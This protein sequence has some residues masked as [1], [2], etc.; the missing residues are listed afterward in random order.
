MLH[1]APG[2]KFYIKSEDRYVSAVDLKNSLDLRKQVHPNIQSVQEVNQ[3][4]EVVRITVDEHHNFYVSEHEIL[5]HNFIDIGVG[6]T[7]YFGVGGGSVFT[8]SFIV[9]TGALIGGAVV[10][11]VKKNCFPS[12]YQRKLQEIFE[13]RAREQ[14]QPID[15]NQGFKPSI[16]QEEKKKTW[17]DAARPKL[18]DKSQGNN[19]L[20]FPIDQNKQKTYV[21][22]SADDAL[23]MVQDENKNLG[24]NAH[25]FPIDQVKQKT[26]IIWASIPGKPTEKDGFF[27]PK[28][29]DGEKVPSSNGK[30]GWQDKNGSIWVPSGA[31][32]HGGPHWDVQHADGSYDNVYPGGKVRP[33][34]R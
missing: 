13:E 15:Q 4:L 19:T 34:K 33:G 31:A 5:A 20:P 16:A 2:H 24:D 7:L 18:Q 28:K 8:W 14:N 3:E 22:V 10:Y 21:D 30:I 25:R 32:G 1:V 26:D 6:F 9:N 12:D 17:V 11:W 27:P 23:P 29:W